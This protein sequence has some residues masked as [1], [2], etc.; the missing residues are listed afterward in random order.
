M[1]KKHLIIGFILILTI[2]SASAATLSDV[3]TSVQ[4]EL[5]KEFKEATDIKW[6]TTKKFYKAS[7]SINGQNLEAFFSTD[8]EFI[9]VSRNITF[10]QLPLVLLRKAVEKS[11]DNKLTELFEISSDR[12]TEYYMSLQNAKEKTIIYKADGEYW[13]RY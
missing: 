13:S 7:F 1:K 6:K 4:N 12:G 5:Q 9:G 11:K 3:P 2:Y 10:E 8:G